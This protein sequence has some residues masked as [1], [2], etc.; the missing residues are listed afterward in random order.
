MVYT[1]SVG[2]E[3]VKKSDSQKNSE[4][5]NKTTKLKQF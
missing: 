4:N 2:K 5:K 3:I 1:Y